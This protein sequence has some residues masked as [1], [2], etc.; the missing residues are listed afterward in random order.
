MKLIACLA[1]SAF[2]TLNYNSFINGLHKT[3]SEYPPMPC[4]G[5]RIGRIQCPPLSQTGNHRTPS[6]SPNPVRYQLN[7]FTTAFAVLHL[8]TLARWRPPMAAIFVHR[9]SLGE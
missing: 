5:R 2:K 8:V 1:D 7:D 3:K 6:G 9:Q 4:A